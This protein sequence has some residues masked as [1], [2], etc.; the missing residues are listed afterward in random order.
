[1][2]HYLPRSYEW[3]DGE[4]TDEELIGTCALCIPRFCTCG[5]RH[6]AAQQEWS[7]YADGPGQLVVIVGWDSRVGTDI[8]ELIIRDAMVAAVLG[9]IAA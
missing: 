9:D 6:S 2:G 5:Y 8:G 3:D 7:A 1:V 4:P